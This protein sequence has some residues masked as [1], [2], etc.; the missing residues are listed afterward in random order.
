MPEILS[1]EKVPPQNLEAEAAVLGS[2]LMDKEAVSNVLEFIDKESF[3]NDANQ[4]VFETI[5]D[6]FNN[7]K[8]IDIITVTNE[9]KSKGLLE[10]I[11]YTGTQGN[12]SNSKGLWTPKMIDSLDKVYKKCFK[13][14][15]ATYQVFYCKGVR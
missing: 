11:R 13:D 15:I 6:L 9:L 5:V 2:M 12:G 10:R 1:L 14:I 8:A 4:I 7:S 3:Y